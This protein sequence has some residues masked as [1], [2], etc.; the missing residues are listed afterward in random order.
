[1]EEWLEEGKESDAKAGE[2]AGAGKWKRELDECRGQGQGRGAK[3]QVCCPR[4]CLKTRRCFGKTK[5]KSKSRRKMRN[6]HVLFEVADHYI[7]TYVHE[8]GT[9]SAAAQS[10]SM[11][12]SHLICLHSHFC[13]T[14]SWS[15]SHETGKARPPW[16][17]AILQVKAGESRKRV[18]GR[19]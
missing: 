15:R 4:C 14:I 17:V 1:M 5:C 11:R 19:Y 12:T 16:N 6:V 13:R 2:Q 18:H 8:T 7:C 9:L 3:S 10:I